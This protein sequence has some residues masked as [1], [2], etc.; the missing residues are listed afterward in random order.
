M[1]QSSWHIPRWFHQMGSPKW[2]YDIAGRLQPWFAL[3]AAVLLIWGSVWGLAF[4]PADYQQGN[5]F[6]IMYVHVPAAILA[7]SVFL[8]MAVAGAVGI[9]WKMKV[10]FMVARSC[11]GM[12]ASFT[13]IALITGAIWG[14]PTWV[15]IYIQI[16]KYM[17][18][19]IN[20]YIYIYINIYI[21]MCT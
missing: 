14:K 10:A 19:Y 13:L 16:Y 8:G 5:S 20:I 15:Y 2:F 3:A 6:R 18:A 7:Q 17:H 12:G 1:T 21:Y 11:I 9:V 4:A